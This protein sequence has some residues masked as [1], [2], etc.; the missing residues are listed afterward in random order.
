MDEFSPSFPLS[1]DAVIITVLVVMLIAVI[2]YMLA[3]AI[4]P[5]VRKPSSCKATR[6]KKTYTME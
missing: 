2:P 1:I 5:F 4:L 3:K 6:V